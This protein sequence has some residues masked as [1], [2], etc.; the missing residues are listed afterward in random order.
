MALAT[1]VLLIL[2]GCATARNAVTQVS[3]ETPSIG[4]PGT[5]P[6]STAGSSTLVATLAP[7]APNTKG[8]GTARLQLN[9]EQKTVCFVIHVT[10]IALPSTG[11][12]IHSGAAGATGPIIVD[13]TAPNAQGVSTGCA[14]STTALINNITQ[15]PADYYVLVHNAAYPDGAVRGQFSTCGPHMNC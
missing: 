7:A 4:T 1:V 5:A 6:G 3:T 12:H 13:L 14:H 8:S 15:H 10:D 2:S 9:P 11:A